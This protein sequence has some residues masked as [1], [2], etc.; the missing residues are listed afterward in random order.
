MKRTQIKSALNNMVNKKCHI[1]YGKKTKEK[2]TWVSSINEVTHNYFVLKKIEPE[3]GLEKFRPGEI[4]YFII[5]GTDNNYSW[6]AKLIK[7]KLT[8]KQDI[9]QFNLPKN[10]I[11]KNT[12]VETENEIE[13][14]KVLLKYREEKVKTHFAGIKKNKIFLKNNKKLKNLN[15]QYNFLIFFKDGNVKG[16]ATL[17]KIDSSYCLDNLRLTKQNKKSFVEFLKFVRIHNENKNVV[18]SS[19]NK[20]KTVKNKQ[21]SRKEKRDIQKNSNLYS[22]VEKIK[23]LPTLSNVVIELNKVLKNDKTSAKK[24]AGILKKDYALSSKILTL[25]NSAYYSLRRK[26]QNIQDAISYLGNEKIKEVATTVTVFKNLEYENE[27]FSLK[28]LWLHSVAVAEYS[29]LCASFSKKV[30]PEDAY[31]AG[32]LHDLGKIFLLKYLPEKINKVIMHSKKNNLKM[33]DSE[34]DI[35]NYDH[36]MIGQW[37]TKIWKFPD[38]I[39]NTCKYHNVSFNK[40]KKEVPQYLQIINHVSIANKIVNKKFESYSGSYGEY[41]ID[42][43]EVNYTNIPLKKALQFK[44]DVIS[45]IEKAESVLDVIRE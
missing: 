2:R 15:D 4:F 18:K 32:L 27:H 25:I 41:E 30:E 16:K 38:Y 5:E 40:R 13:D 22:M 36:N 31:T 20:D 21:K 1:K 8:L 33:Y 29:K 17:K 35:L 44:T 14:I 28:K 10:I 23:E 42:I 43:K 11:K 6:K 45:K 24:I 12:S 39:I 3:L 34:Y 9:Y 26:V 7:V 37:L 19:K